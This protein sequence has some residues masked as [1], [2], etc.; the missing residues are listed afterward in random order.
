MA[1][2]D[3]PSLHDFRFRA[4]TVEEKQNAE[5]A[6]AWFANHPN[7]FDPDMYIAI[8][9]RGRALALKEHQRLN[10]YEYAVAYYVFPFLGAAVAVWIIYG[11]LS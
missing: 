7:E 4:Q 3:R 2:W 9:V 1:L 5:K 8:G 6:K 10:P 11:V